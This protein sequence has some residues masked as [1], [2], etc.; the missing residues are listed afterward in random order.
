MLESDGKNGDDWVNIPAALHPV[1]RMQVMQRMQVQRVETH[2]TVSGLE[3][4]TDGY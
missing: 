1:Y 3:K 4:R 2:I